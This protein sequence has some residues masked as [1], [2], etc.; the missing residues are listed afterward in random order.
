MS[1]S[2]LLTSNLD[3]LFL[4]TE[5]GKTGAKTAAQS[6]P[7]GVLGEDRI[8]ENVAGLF[9]HAVAMPTG[10]LLESSFDVPFKVSDDQLRHGSRNLL[11]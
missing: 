6:G 11:S 9:F 2:S 8:A 4:E 1:W 10:P 7:H 5:V 3:Y